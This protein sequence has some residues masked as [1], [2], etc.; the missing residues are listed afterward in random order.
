MLFA[1]WTKK[2]DLLA[3]E[4][5]LAAKHEQMPEDIRGRHWIAA[6]NLRRVA[7]ELDMIDVLRGQE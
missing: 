4:I 7:R 2:L 6:A 5:A 1:E 3:D